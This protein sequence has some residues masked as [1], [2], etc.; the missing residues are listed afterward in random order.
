MKS[1]FHHN[2]PGREKHAKQ[3]CRGLIIPYSQRQQW[4]SAHRGKDP[5]HY[6]T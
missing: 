5:N 4:Q 2:H 6:V 3:G 1:V